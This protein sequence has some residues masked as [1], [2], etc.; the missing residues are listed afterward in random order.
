[1]SELV[2][3]SEIIQSDVID[4]LGKIEKNLIDGTLI[5]ASKAFAS[6]IPSDFYYFKLYFGCKY[7]SSFM[8]LN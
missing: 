8:A 3:K 5:S 2:L 4:E 6:T 1:M 7:L